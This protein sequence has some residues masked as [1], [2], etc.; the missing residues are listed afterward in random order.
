MY[1]LLTKEEKEEIF[2]KY[3]NGINTKKLSK[4]YHT[5]TYNIK[6][7]LL[8]LGIDINDPNKSVG[9]IKV[10]NGYWYIRE[11]NETLAKTCRNRSEFRDKS[12]SAYKA[13]LKEG[14]I[15]EYEKL[16]FTDKKNFPSFD[17]P[18]HLVYAYEIKEYNSVYV[19][20][21]TDLK[22]RDKTHRNPTDN[23]TLYNFCNSNNI[24]IPKPIILDE[25]LN[26]FES[27]D[28]ENKWIKTYKKNGW[29]I[30]NKQKTGI[31]SSSLGSTAAKWNY[32]TCKSAASLCKNKEEFKKKYSRAHNVSRTNGWIDEFFPF[33]S[34]RENGCFDTL[35]KCK[36]ACKGYNTI[37]GI[38]NNYPFLYHKISKNKWTEE[39]RKFI[40]E[41]KERD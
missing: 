1:K 37:L 23:D 3:K 8:E 40:V 20:R 16:Y 38:R 10:P 27:Q 14:W 22:R 29:G 13:A 30:L 18:I 4:E 19:G 32:E 33:N 11:N 39:I 2:E 35:E 26:A 6:N 41:E 17:L 25:N 28:K 21:T 9:K 34:K 12:S 36:E 5:N 7:V 15:D 24:E 31:G